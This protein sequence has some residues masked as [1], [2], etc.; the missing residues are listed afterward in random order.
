MSSYP[1]NADTVKA[2][3]TSQGTTKKRMQRRV[4]MRKQI[5]GSQFRK[6]GQQNLEAK[7][8]RRIATQATGARENRWELQSHAAIRTS[9]R[10]A[11]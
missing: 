4:R 6:Q 5:S 2:M 3:A 11:Q 9:N 8:Q 1:S 10:R 7:E